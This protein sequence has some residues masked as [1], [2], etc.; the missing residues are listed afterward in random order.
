MQCLTAASAPQLQVTTQT[1]VSMQL[2]NTPKH[3]ATHYTAD[4]H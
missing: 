1:G 3:V 2:R 4:C